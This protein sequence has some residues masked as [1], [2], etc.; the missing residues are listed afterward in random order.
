MT[1]VSSCGMLFQLTVYHCGCLQNNEQVC[2]CLYKGSLV[3]KKLE[4]FCVEKILVQK[5]HH[6]IYESQSITTVEF[7]TN[8]FIG[9]NIVYNSL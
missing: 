6:D 3:L 4:C 8:C 5:T 2:T 7:E 9:S 1:L